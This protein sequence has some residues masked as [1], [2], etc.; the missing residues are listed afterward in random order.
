[1]QKIFLPINTT[2]K[3]FKTKLVS[4][5]FSEN[6]TWEQNF[7]ISGKYHSIA[8][9]ILNLFFLHSVIILLSAFYS[10]H[11]TAIAISQYYFQ[12]DGRIYLC[13]VV[14]RIFVSSPV[15]L[16]RNLWHN[17]SDALLY[18]ALY[19]A[20]RSLLWRS[21]ANIKDNTLHGPLANKSQVPARCSRCQLS[22]MKPP[23]FVAKSD[24]WNYV[25]CMYVATHALDEDERRWG[26]GRRYGPRF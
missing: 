25:A 10:F 26:N 8:H 14:S 21:L 11:L 5:T 23:T 12:H 22:L 13:I 24:K 2:I 3:E 7:Y 20:R 19:I 1:M 6:Y 4:I 16:H 15:I 9:I 17:S 18:N